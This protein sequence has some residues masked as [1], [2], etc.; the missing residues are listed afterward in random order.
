MGNPTEECV[1]HAGPLRLVLA[2]VERRP[3]LAARGPDRG[4][5]RSLVAAGGEERI[6]S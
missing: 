6:S 1:D 5:V 3:E 2:S 4:A